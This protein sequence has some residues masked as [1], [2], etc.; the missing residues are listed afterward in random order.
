MDMHGAVA[1]DIHGVGM[2]CGVTTPTILGQCGFKMNLVFFCGVVGT[3][4]YK[5]E[6]CLM[7]LV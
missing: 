3:S 4:P 5:D 6:Q 1:S 2:C 7:P